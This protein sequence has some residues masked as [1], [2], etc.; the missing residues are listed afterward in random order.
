MYKQPEWYLIN[1]RKMTQ[2]VKINA[3]ISKNILFNIL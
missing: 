1:L 3:F 2:V